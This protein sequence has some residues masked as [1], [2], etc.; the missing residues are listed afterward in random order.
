[1]AIPD[2]DANNRVEPE[3]TAA[4]DPSLSPAEGHVEHTHTHT[5]I[6]TVEHHHHAPGSAPI[7]QVDEAPRGDS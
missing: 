2:T 5:P 7:D 4:L 6:P 3:P 1:M